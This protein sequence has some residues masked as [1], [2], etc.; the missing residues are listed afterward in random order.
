MLSLKDRYLA[1][2]WGLHIGDA[3]WAPYETKTSDEVAQLLQAQQLRFHKY[4]NPWPADDNGEFL[5]AGRPTDDTDQA[6]DLCHSL[7]LRRGVDQHHLR[8][9]L[10]G[11]VI[12]GKSR[13]WSGQATG[14]GGTTR[15][16]LSEN[17]QQQAEA[18][19]NP[20][21][22]NGSLM[23][24]A[25]MALLLGPTASGYTSATGVDYHMVK[26]MS[27]VTHSHPDSVSACWLYV[28]MLRNAMA[29]RDIADI[30]PAN[31]FDQR[32]MKYLRAIDTGCGLPE[33]PGSF[34]AGWG[35]A[36]YTLKV[37]L[38]MIRTANSFEE[39]I[40]DVG[41]VGG[42]TDTYGAVAGGLAGAIYGTKAI[43]RKW[44]NAILGKKPMQ[45][46]AQQ[47]FAAYMNRTENV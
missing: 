30:Q 4:K 22:S 37:A 33:D 43:P 19:S 15:R 36:E 26:A 18:R 2:L 16:A 28:R 17:L 10:Q 7:L 41:L 9:S 27:E 20:I 31:D 25:P 23:R 11:S 45:S 32:I 21:A 14:A 34:K 29:N 1:T 44:R 40:L 13:L 42:D 47:L 8:L 35:G 6:A 24:S 39:T 12:H 46:Y 3:I 38:H 5:P